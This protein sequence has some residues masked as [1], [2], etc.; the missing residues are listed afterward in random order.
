MSDL[1]PLNEGPQAHPTTS[2][3]C[4]PKHHS[5]LLLESRIHPLP[6]PF[7]GRNVSESGKT[8]ALA[9]QSPPPSLCQSTAALA[10]AGGEP[11][12]L[13]SCADVYLLAI[14]RKKNDLD[15]R[16]SD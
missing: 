16:Y 2:E 15:Y 6:A 13:T 1:D 3:R 11:A 9:V 12:A 4:V 7:R 14:K 5:F 10:E 8:M